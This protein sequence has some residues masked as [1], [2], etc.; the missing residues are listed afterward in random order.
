MHFTPG[1]PYS[2]RHNQAVTGKKFN[3]YFFWDN[4]KGV[5]FNPPYFFYT[6]GV[7]KKFFKK[8]YFFL[9]VPF[10]SWYKTSSK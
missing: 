8:F 7:I 2:D 3:L 9:D 4:P 5:F 6:I 10:I 1:S